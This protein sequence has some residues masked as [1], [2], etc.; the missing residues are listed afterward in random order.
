[1][2]TESTNKP[3]LCHPQASWIVAKNGEAFCPICGRGINK[4]LRTEVPVPEVNLVEEPKTVA[5]VFAAEELQTAEVKP[6]VDMVNHPP[7]YTKGKMETIDILED[8]VQYYPDP[9]SGALAWNVVKYLSRAPHKGA[10]TV[11]VQKAGWYFDRLRK[12]LGS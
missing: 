2:E 10:F 5:K 12:R 8:I 9:V 11:D 1:M 6:T 7:H 3:P 4:P